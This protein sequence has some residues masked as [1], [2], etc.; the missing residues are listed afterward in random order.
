MSVSTVVDDSVK[1]LLN[2]FV[3]D[4]NFQQLLDC[5]TKFATILEHLRLSQKAPKLRR[6]CPGLVHQKSSFFDYKSDFDVVEIVLRMLE[7]L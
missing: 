2:Y 6:H 4:Y 5:L 7:V 3:E 1:V